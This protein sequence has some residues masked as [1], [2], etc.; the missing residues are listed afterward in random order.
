MRRFDGGRGRIAVPKRGLRDRDRPKAGNEFFLAALFLCAITSVSVSQSAGTPHQRKA[1]AKQIDSVFSAVTSDGDPGLAVLVRANGHAIFEKGYGVRDLRTKSKIGGATNFRLASVTKQFTAMAVMLLAHDLKLRYVDRLTDVFPDFPAYGKSISIRNLLNHTSGLEDY[2]DLLM[3]ANPNA[4]PEKIPQIKDAGVL[5]LMKQQT[6]TKF[7]PGTNWEYC[8]TG[9]A[10]LAMIVEKKS[11]K[12]FGQFLHDRIFAPLKMENTI[13]FENGK[14]EVSNRA[15]G[16]SKAGDAWQETDQSPTS[17]VLGDGG[18]YSSVEDLAKWDDALEQ[19][20][21]LDE[22]DMQ[23][24]L[25]PALRRPAVDS[26]GPTDSAGNPIL[27]GFG[28]FL[29]PYKR[30]VRMYH[31]GETIGF[32]TTIER[33]TGDKVT[34]IVLCN[35]DDLNPQALA[36]KVADLILPSQN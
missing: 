36:E 21:L 25:A 27:Y 11:G 18:I 19:Y 26:S 6:S 34:I 17:A 23:P 10:I 8:N 15:Y 33:F 28:W 16:H 3:K 20:T 13:A 2:G 31:D 30:H 7:M 24:A 32:R 29:D 4:P 1:D 35:R 22:Q 9:Y 14:N 5:A 12:P